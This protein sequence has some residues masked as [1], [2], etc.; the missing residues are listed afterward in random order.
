MK[1]TRK[2]SRFDLARY[3]DSPGPGR[4]I[5]EFP[6]GQAI[7]SQDSP[8]EA[9]YYIRQ[10]TVKLTTVSKNGKE[11]VI[12]LLNVG[13]FFGE[14][15]LTGQTKRMETAT[16]IHPTSVLMIQK[17]EMVRMLHAEHAFSDRFISHIL[18]RSVRFQEDL[19]DQLFNSTEK[20]LA[21]ALLLL[22]SYG[23]KGRPEKIIPKISQETLAG[24]VG[25][26][27][28]RVNIFM[29]KFRRLGFIKYNGGLYVN[30]S[31]LNVVLHD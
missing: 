24:I 22:A 31:L 29:N 1:R 15:C 25:T 6:Q 18:K 5:L 27:R 13:D 12:A 23:K 17:R 28:G 2:S 9:V 11:A 4:A 14:S 7:F 26:N 8:A 21:R 20:R 30:S 3:L 19:V 16:A 10:G